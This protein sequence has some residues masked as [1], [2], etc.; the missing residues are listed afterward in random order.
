MVFDLALE[1]CGI[2]FIESMQFDETLV[3][4]YAIRDGSSYGDRNPELWISR[5]KDVEVSDCKFRLQYFCKVDEIDF[6]LERC[7]TAVC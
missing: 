4:G 7:P 3:I 2:E 6:G 1:V 5:I